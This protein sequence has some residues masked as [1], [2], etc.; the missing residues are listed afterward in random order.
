MKQLRRKVIHLGSQPVHSSLSTH[1]FCCCGR[2][3]CHH[4]SMTAQ[5]H[6]IRLYTIL[7][8]VPASPH[9]APSVLGTAFRYATVAAI[10]LSIATPFPD[11]IRN[12]LFQSGARVV[13]VDWCAIIDITCSSEFFFTRFWMLVLCLDVVRQEDSLGRW[14]CHINGI[15]R[16]CYMRLNTWLG[17]QFLCT[18]IHDKHCLV[19]D[20][21]CQ[22]SVRNGGA[23]RYRA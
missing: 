8:I 18:T 17:S 2:H 1:P 7:P 20:C 3:C 15:G 14:R 16:G 13:G 22:K 6:V 5:S 4:W 19:P 10:C 21:V 11:M 23:S 12:K 9:Q